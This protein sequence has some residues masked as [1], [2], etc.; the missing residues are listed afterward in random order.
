MWSRA[1]QEEFVFYPSLH[2]DEEISISLFDEDRLGPPEEIGSWHSSPLQLFEAIVNTGSIPAASA[3]DA[4]CRSAEVRGAIIAGKVL[5]CPLVN[6]SSGKASGV[7]QIEVGFLGDRSS[8][9]S[10]LA[11]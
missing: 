10:R 2:A 4:A 5:D 1:D 7:V 3:D 11:E 6:T 8:W 9:S